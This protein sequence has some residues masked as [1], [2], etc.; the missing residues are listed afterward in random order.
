MKIITDRK[1]IKRNQKIGQITTYASMGVLAVGLYLSFKQ[2]YI[3]WSFLAL[4]LGFALS[5]IGIYYGSRWGRSPRPDEGI[6]AALKGLDGRYSL[7]HYTS[8]VGHLLIGPAGLWVLSPYYQKGTITYDEKKNRWGHKSG[9][10]YMKKFAQESLGRPD[11]EIKHLK[12]DMQKF[13]VKNSPEISFPETKVV[14]V[15][16]NE[17]AILEAENAPYPTIH[18]TK[19]KDFM[20]RQAKENPV[21]QDVISILEEKLPKEETL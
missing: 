19:L 9:N 12:E 6:S 10:L 11:L 17:K 13:L 18:I 4:L 8:P 2:M 20:R 5:Q 7:Y 15:F 1:L 14:L 16:T 21:N 3:T